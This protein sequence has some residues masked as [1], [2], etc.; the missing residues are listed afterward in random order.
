MT[1]IEKLRAAMP[2]GVDAFITTDECTRLYLTKFHSTDGTVFVTKQSAVLYADFRYIEAAEKEAQVLKEKKELQVKEKF[3]NKKAELE[4]EVQQRTQ[5]IQQGENRLKQREI[6]LNQRQEEL[7]RK[8]Q[9]IEQ[10]QQRF[11]NEKKVLQLK[12]EELDKMQIKEREKL[13]ELS[14]K[15]GEG[16]YAHVSSIDG[17]EEYDP[18][19]DDGKDEEWIVEDIECPNCKGVAKFSHPK[20][21]TFGCLYCPKCDRE[22]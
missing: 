15:I 9:E 6:S 1:R 20:N 8:K 17:D 16:C 3:L 14:G 13:E 11:E 21:N 18:S 19:N 2:E 7:G 10:A 4:K 12:K 5:K 22:Y